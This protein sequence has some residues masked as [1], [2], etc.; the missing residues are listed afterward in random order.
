MNKKAIV[1]LSGG[2]DS[3]VTAAIARQECEKLYFLHIDYGQKTSRREKKAFEDITKYY[4]P[5][6]K[7]IV[8]LDYLKDIG[9]SSL[10][11]SSMQVEDHSDSK[12]IPTS[13]VPFRN[14]HLLA[15]ATSWAEVIK[16]GY[17]YIGAVEEDSSGYP[18]CRKEFFEHFEKTIRL[19]TKNEFPI[20]ICT[21]VIDLSKAEIVKIGNKLKAPFHLSWSCYRNEELACGRCDS[22]NLRLRAF[23][24]AGI[25]DPLPYE[26]GSE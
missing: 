16:A 9:G 24:K 1:L 8:K 4:K 6:E 5:S 22:C 21:P 20:S 14:A 3:L 10:T 13:Y 18:D 7:K 11:D 15:I 26:D 19:G 2:M 17:I 12:A 23:K 25:K